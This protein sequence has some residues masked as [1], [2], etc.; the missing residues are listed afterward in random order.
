MNS[1]KGFTAVE[2]IVVLIAFALLS[3]FI[4]IPFLVG[5]DGLLK[6]L[7]IIALLLIIIRLL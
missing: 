5:L 6:V 7:A 4:V 2:L 3:A 1:Q